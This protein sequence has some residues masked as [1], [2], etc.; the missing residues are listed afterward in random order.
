ML[1][2][3]TATA[4][5]VA[6]SSEGESFAA[7][8]RTQDAR[9]DAKEQPIGVKLTQLYPGRTFRFCFT[10]QQMATAVSDFIWSRDDLR[11]TRD[12]VYMAMW[13]DDSYSRDLIEGFW[14]AL[15]K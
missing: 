9:S 7:P 12:P 15:S 5:R 1:L 2:L 8:E 3:T 13:N 6:P 11:P 4:D 14:G 10:N